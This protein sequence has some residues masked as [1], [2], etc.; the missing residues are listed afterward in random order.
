MVAMDLKFDGGDA[1]FRTHEGS[2]MAPPLVD[3]NLFTSD[4]AL[5]EA[6]DREGAG[7]AAGELGVFGGLLGKEATIEL[8]FLAN[9]NPPVVFTHDRV[10]RRR[11]EVEFHPAWHELM[12]MSVA[13]GIHASP[14]SSPRE[15]A[16]VARAAG[17]FMLAQIEAGVM[18]P[19]T[20]TYAVVPALRRQPSLAAEWEPR[21]FSRRY[22]RRFRP[23]GEKTG[24]LFG[25]G[26][27][28]KQGGSDL[29]SN[30]TQAVPVG[31]GG[32]GAAYRIT[33]HKWFF[34]APMSDA[35]LVTAQAPGGLSCFLVPRWTPDDAVN[36]LRLQRLKDK[37]GNRANA[38]SEVEFQNAWAFLVGDEGRGVATI[39][40]MVN[41]TRLDCAL[42]S[43]ALV[44]QAL[45]QAMF[46]ASHRKAFERRLIEQPLMAN[47]LADL[48]IESEASTALA[49]RLARAY[50]RRDDAA[51]ATEAAWR[52]VMTP[53]I[54]YFTTKRAALAV[55]EAMEVFGGVGYV[56]ESIMPR[57]YREAPLNSIWEG[58][59]NV[60][61]L[62]VRR[63]LRASETADAVLVE[64][65]SARGGDPRLDRFVAALEPRLRASEEA[66]ARTLVERLVLAVAAS[67]LVR[68][69]PHA[70]ADAFCA[71]RL[72]GSWTGA[73]GTLPAGVD[74]AV[75]ARRAAAGSP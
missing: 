65:A 18:C 9:K 38:S 19:T 61:C 69:A 16:H 36:G 73:L 51:N 46:H 2:N 27:T 54:K 24:A 33:G 23:A 32:A 39:M 1:Q 28:E 6:V 53:A 71:S 62:D 35:F 52:R 37:L 55:A 31:Q 70:V 41:H 13:Q 8:G 21:I 74:T 56:E 14:W 75:I 50:D 34:S 3:Y 64:L 12:G 44:R 66:E 40:E 25:M 7:W 63:A 49:M 43:A 68:F 4:R 45:A 42:G 67:L 20:M 72:E 10:G 58:S 59:G 5:A 17:A 30:T 22:D 57:L 29:R 47:V 26:M 15:G 60:M 11:D 48:A